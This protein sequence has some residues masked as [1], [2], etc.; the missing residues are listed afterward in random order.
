MRI[1]IVF[2]LQLFIA[3]RAVFALADLIRL[4]R[5]ARIALHAEIVYVLIVRVCKTQPRNIGVIAVEYK[6]SLVSFKKFFDLQYQRF[7][8]AVPVKL[9]A[10]KVEYH[11]RFQLQL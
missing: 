9:V 4:V 11:Q 2:I 8:L 7:D 6:I 5:C 1:L 3:E 10:E